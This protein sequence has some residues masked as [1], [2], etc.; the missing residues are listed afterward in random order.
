MGRVVD[1][2]VVS[3]IGWRVLPCDQLFDDG[4][5]LGGRH[6]AL[7]FLGNLE[8]QYLEQALEMS[9]GNK[10]KAAGLLGMTFRSFRYRLRK[11]GMDD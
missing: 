8:R 10:T 4:I 6:A 7:P 3:S 2:D 11:F 5:Q 9:N 1:P